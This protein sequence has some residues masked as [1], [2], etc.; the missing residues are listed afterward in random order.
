MERIVLASQS[1][2]RKQLLEWAEIEFDIIV[3]QTDES[4]P[5]GIALEEL[6]IYIAREKAKSIQAELSHEEDHSCC[7]YDCG[8]W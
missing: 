8:S 4:F 6:A 5:P 7:R 3:Q 2:R 1:P